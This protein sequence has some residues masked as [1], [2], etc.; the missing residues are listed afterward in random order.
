LARCELVVLVTVA[1]V[2][3]VTAAALV[4]AGLDSSR[5]VLAVRGTSRS[6]PRPRIGQ[7]LGLEVLGEIGYDPASLRPSGLELQRIRRTTQRLAH[8]I[9][10]RSQNEVL[11]A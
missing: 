1:E 6:L 7:L 9:L 11:A 2:R 5:T 3:A 8:E 4:A 10:R